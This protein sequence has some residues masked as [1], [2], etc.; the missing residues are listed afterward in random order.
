MNEKVC[1]IKIDEKLHRMAKINAV[2]KGINLGKYIE[3]ILTPKIEADYKE[4]K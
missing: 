2:I 1:H 4:R 3:K